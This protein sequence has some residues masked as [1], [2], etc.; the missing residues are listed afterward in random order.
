[1]QLHKEGRTL[2]EY[3]FRC[4]HLCVGACGNQRAT[5]EVFL[6]GSPSLSLSLSLSYGDRLAT[7][8]VQLD[9]LAHELQGSFHVPVLGG[10]PGTHCPIFLLTW[11][12]GIQTV[13]ELVPDCAISRSP[14]VIIQ[15]SQITEKS[16]LL[17]VSEEK[18]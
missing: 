10:T 6:S 5:P 7:E 3:T 13:P 9:L 17:V 14:H 18:F 8:I 12:M 2:R 15:R 16:V 11:A 1:M 4:V